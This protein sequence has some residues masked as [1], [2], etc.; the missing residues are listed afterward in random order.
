MQSVPMPNVIAHFRSQQGHFVGIDSARRH[1]VEF[2]NGFTGLKNTC[3]S[4][5]RIRP[6]CFGQRI[7]QALRRKYIVL[8]FTQS[9]L[10]SFGSAIAQLR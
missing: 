8:R 2:A 7:K 10:E 1:S 4:L 6:V 5:P 9:P 3:Q